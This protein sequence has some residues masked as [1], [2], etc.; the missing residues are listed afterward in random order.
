MLTRSIET[1]GGKFG[2]N[3]VLYGEHALKGGRSLNIDAFQTQTIRG[4]AG[5]CS[6][7]F[8]E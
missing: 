6:E 4:W 5:V 8:L 7:L 1:R 3:A 2:S